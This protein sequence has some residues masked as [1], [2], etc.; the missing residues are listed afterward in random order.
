MMKWIFFYFLLL[1]T[2]ICI[3]ILLRYKENCNCYSLDKKVKELKI[4]YRNMLKRNRTMLDL[5]DDSDK[6]GEKRKKYKYIGNNCEPWISR[7]CI[8]ILDHILSYNNI[9]LE[10][11]SGSSTLWLGYRIKSL[12]SIENSYSWYSI[13]KNKIEEQEM[14]NI[15]KYYVIQKDNFEYCKNDSKYISNFFKD[16][17]C[18][19]SYVVSDIIPNI[20]YDYI[21][22]DG[23]ARTG[24]LIRALHLIKKENGIL[25]LDNS[26]RRRY[27][28]AIDLVPKHWSRYDFNYSNG[29]VTLWIS[30]F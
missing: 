16:Y 9:G 2:Y 15:I 24:C 8:F 20:E 18:Y 13:V 25:I 4:I 27:K 11:S 3:I 7:E 14:S 26:E 12:I 22:I 23:R 30:H 19:K 6:L 17:T 29:V 1:L 10:W 21:S 5:C 28:W